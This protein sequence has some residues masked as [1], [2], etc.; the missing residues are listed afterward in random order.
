MTNIWSYVSAICEIVGA[1]FIDC[2]D[3]G[4][5]PRLFKIK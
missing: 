2:V 4:M 5:R 3:K 1:L